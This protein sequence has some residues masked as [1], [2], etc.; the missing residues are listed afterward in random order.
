LRIDILGGADVKIHENT[1]LIT[2]GT[3]GIGLDLAKS[4][5]GLENQVIIC[6][7]REERLREIKDQHPTIHTRVCDVSDPE[8]RK[9][10]FNWVSVLKL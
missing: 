2:G 3:S 9:S 6:G 8:D 7:R 10:L 4:L 1:V 5:L